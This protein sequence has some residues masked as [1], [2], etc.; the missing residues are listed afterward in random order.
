MVDAVE[1]LLRARQH[2]EALAVARCRLPAHA[3]LHARAAAQWAQAAT[4]EGNFE[5]AA[6]LYLR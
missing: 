6:M 5:M 2:R 1:L 4:Y 3:E